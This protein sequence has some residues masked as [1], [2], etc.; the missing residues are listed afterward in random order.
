MTNEAL[1]AEDFYTSFLDYKQTFEEIFVALNFNLQPL[2]N[3][4][5]LNSEQKELDFQYS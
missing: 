5:T 2:E 1:T 3:F 4:Y